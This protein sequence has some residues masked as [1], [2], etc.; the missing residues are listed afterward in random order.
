MLGYV[1]VYWNTL[2]TSLTR[3]I[4]NQTGTFTGAQNVS[5]SSRESDEAM[6]RRLQ[7]EEQQRAANATKNDEKTSTD[8]DMNDLRRRRLQRLGL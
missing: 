1:Y 7:K 2:F 8:S 6:A 5:G 4:P 3:W